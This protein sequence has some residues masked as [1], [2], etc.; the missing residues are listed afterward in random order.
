MKAS[1]VKF[2]PFSKKLNKIAFLQKKKQQRIGYLKMQ[3]N[4][5][6]KFSFIIFIYTLSLAATDDNTLQQAYQNYNEG[7]NAHNIF[8]R[9]HAF[10]QSLSEYIKVEED[11][12][13]SNKMGPL[14]YNIANPFTQL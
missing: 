5:L 13:E 14:Y 7:M 6:K 4:Y 2:A 11:L 3:K 1:K 9:Q 12:G 8:Q 10:N